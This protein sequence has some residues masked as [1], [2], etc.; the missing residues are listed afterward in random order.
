MRRKRVEQ[1]DQLEDCHHRVDERYQE[2]EV[3]DGADG[4][5]GTMDR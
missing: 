5:E 4:C 3:R 2:P 1:G